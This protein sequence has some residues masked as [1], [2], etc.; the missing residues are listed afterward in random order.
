MPNVNMPDIIANDVSYPCWVGW[1]MGVRVYLPFDVGFNFC[2]LDK[3]WYEEE[4]DTE[5]TRT[6]RFAKR[7]DHSG[8][9]FKINKAEFYTMFDKRP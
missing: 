2:P 9:L 8:I 6:I 3:T 1:D 5:A 4:V 7:S